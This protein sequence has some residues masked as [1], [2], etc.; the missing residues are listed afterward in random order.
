METGAE[1]LPDEVDVP[2]C[3]ISDRCR[4]GKQSGG[5]CVVRQKGLVC[6]SALIE[7]GIVTRENALDH[8]LSF[9]AHFVATSEEVAE[10]LKDR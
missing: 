3:P 2:D 1:H 9:N 7:A 8:P 5:V 4:H 6:E 10:W